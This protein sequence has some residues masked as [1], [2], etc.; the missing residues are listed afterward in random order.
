[1]FEEQ[2]RKIARGPAVGRRQPRYRY[3]TPGA[4]LSAT[5]PGLI[6]SLQDPWSKATQQDLAEVPHKL[7]ILFLGDVDTQ[8]SFAI[9][10]QNAESIRQTQ[11]MR[12]KKARLPA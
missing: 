4:K 10:A 1:M 5:R 8:P 3:M 9:Q 12:P 6:C 2:G 11:R 7:S